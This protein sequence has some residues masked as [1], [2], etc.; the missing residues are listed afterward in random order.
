MRQSNIRTRDGSVG[1]LWKTPRYADA[2]MAPVGGG[3]FSRRGLRVKKF[4]FLAAVV[5]AVAFAAS[6]QAQPI[7]HRTAVAAGE[8]TPTNGSFS[9]RFPIAFNDIE[10]RAEDP[11]APTL[12]IH[13]LSGV[14]SEGLRFSATETPLPGQP[15]PMDNFMEAAGK[16]PGA[17]VSDVTREQNGETSMLSFSLGEPKGGNYF[18]LIRAKGT[19]YMLVIQFP[20]ALRGQAAGKKDDF[21]GSFKMTRP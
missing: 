1:I 12:V 8:A 21:F 5:I 7:T 15:L 14:N 20:E 9:V 17:V 3:C 10:L 4:C 6:A 19:Q 16:R 13:L 11:T 2:M 18:R